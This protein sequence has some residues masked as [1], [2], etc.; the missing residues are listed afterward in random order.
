VQTSDQDEVWSEVVGLVESFPTVC[1]MPPSCKD[2][3]SIPDLSFDHNLCFRCLNESCKPILDIYVSIA[4]QWYKKLLKEMGFDLYNRFMKIR[5]ST[6]TSTPKMGVHLGV[7]MFMFTF[8][9]TLG[10]LSWPMFLQA[11]CL[12]CEPKARVP[13]AP[14]NLTFYMWLIYTIN[15]NLCLVA[16]H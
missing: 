9:H 4:F 10:L 8:S 3:K 5:K 15:I 12:D 1:L 7:W 2:I 14:M 11:P 16:C 6:R 13:I